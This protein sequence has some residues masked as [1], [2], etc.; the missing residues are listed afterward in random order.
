MSENSRPS[1]PANETGCP[2]LESAWAILTERSSVPPPVN[3]EFRCRTRMRFMRGRR[4]LEDPVVLVNTQSNSGALL[5][6][7][8][9]ILPEIIFFQ[10]NQW[11]SR[12]IGP[13]GFPGE[14]THDSGMSALK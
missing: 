14:L 13:S 5:Q 2:N 10:S 12:L 1:G 8:R 6:Q 7:Q 3:M 9:H 4:L 11:I